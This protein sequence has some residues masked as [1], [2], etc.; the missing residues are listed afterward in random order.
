MGRTILTILFSFA[1]FIGFQVLLE[2]KRQCNLKKR[3]GACTKGCTLPKSVTNQNPGTIGDL[4][5]QLDI[6]L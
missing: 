2:K 6:N 1:L 3:L 5:N 4:L